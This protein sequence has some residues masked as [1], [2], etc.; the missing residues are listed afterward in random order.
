[1]APRARSSICRPNP[2]KPQT[3]LFSHRLVSHPPQGI[4]CR[5]LRERDSLLDFIVGVQTPAIFLLP[6]S[7]VVLTWLLCG[8]WFE[9]CSFDFDIFG[10]GSFD[11]SCDQCFGA[12][13]AF[14]IEHS[15]QLHLTHLTRALLGYSKSS[16]YPTGKLSRILP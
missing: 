7:T 8:P 16:E 2:R 10:R 5:S 9:V 11:E 13:K 15:L 14:C 6:S 4:V 1:M 12:L 3:K